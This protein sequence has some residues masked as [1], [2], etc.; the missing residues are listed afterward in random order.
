MIKTLKV[1]GVQFKVRDDVIDTYNEIVHIMGEN[2][3]ILLAVI[4]SVYRIRNRK[5]YLDKVKHSIL[6]N[7]E[8]KLILSVVDFFLDYYKIDKL[9]SKF[10]A[11]KIMRCTLDN[12]S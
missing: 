6:N 12:L 7:V 8:R 11:S 10:I 3:R 4:L 2:E 9:K 5:R 1:V